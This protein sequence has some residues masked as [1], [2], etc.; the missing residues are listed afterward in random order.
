M[1]KKYLSLLAKEFPTIDSAVSEIAGRKY[2]GKALLDKLDEIANKAYFMPACA[3]KYYSA[4]Y[5]WYLWSGACSPLYGKDKMAFFERYFLDNKEL[6][7]E[8]YNAYYHFSEQADVCG[9][10][11]EMFGLDSERG[12]IINGHVPLKIKTAK[13]P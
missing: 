6:Q 5:M 13:A 7:K 11:L 3:E 12:H 10:I 8:N 9:R 1:D 4:D 2:S